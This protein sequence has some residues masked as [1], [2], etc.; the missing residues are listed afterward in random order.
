MG[1]HAII[2]H[3]TNGHPQNCWYPWLRRLQQTYDWHAIAGHVGDLCFINSVR[4][5]AAA[6][7][8]RA[9]TC[10]T[11]SAARRSC[12]TRATE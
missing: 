7:P 12:A 1:H 8:H 5:P 4:D 9:G 2:F 3:G 6:T 11:T 10:A